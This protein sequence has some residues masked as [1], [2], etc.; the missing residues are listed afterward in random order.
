M[1]LC[2]R[3]SPQLLQGFCLSASLA[4]SDLDQG[5]AHKDLYPGDLISGLSI[6]PAV[7]IQ[8]RLLKLRLL[9]IP[10]GNRPELAALDLHTLL[11]LLEKVRGGRVV[12]QGLEFAQPAGPLVSARSAR[13][14]E[15]WP[16]PSIK[17][18]HIQ[19]Y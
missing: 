14:D 8:D 1:Y 18:V 3:F 5:I 11:R 4:V 10:D 12:A 7:A 19:A 13:M 17:S 6:A 15:L 9:Q 16:A 2:L